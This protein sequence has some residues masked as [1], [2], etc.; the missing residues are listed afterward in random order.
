MAEHRQAEG[1]LGD[2]DVAGHNLEVGAG[3]IALALVVARDD[4]R[5]AGEAEANLRRAETMPRRVETHLSVTYRDRVACADRLGGAAK[6]LA[7]A[8]RHDAQR[9]WRREHAAVAG[10]GVVGMAMSDEGAGDRAHGI[11]KEI[12]RRKIKSLG[13]ENQSTA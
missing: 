4:D 3:R 5:A 13:R 10:A 2:E 11:D 12:A 9:L 1:C 7:V 6:R 8:H